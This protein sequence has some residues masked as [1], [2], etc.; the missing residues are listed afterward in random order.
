MKNKRSL[1]LKER[2]WDREWERGARGW[3]FEIADGAL[4]MLDGDLN[5]LVG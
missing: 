3:S 5:L 1:D 4:N 2:E